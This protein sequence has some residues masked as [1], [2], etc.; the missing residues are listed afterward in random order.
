MSDCP[1]C[2]FDL[3]YETAEL[4]ELI[5]CPDCGT[6]LEVVSVDPVILETAPEEQED[7]GE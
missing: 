4:C 6:D 3:T 2:G 1:I 5:P 7:W